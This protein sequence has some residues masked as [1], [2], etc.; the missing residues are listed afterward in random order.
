MA[1]VMEAS[2][3]VRARARAVRLV[4]FDVDG[5]LTD[6]RLWFDD[7]GK[8]MKAFHAQDGLCL[9]LLADHGIA[10]ALITA[11]TSLATLARARDLR[12][13]HVFTAVPDKL[14]CL[15]ALCEKLG[16][17]LD[18]VA[19]MGDDL[20]D[21]PVFPHVALAVGPANSHAW[22]LDRAHWVTPQ[23]GGEGAARAL[24]DLI[25]CERGLR[26]AVLARFGAE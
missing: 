14:V 3:A 23:R 10:V 8:E 15:R 2:E 4:A 5:T 18:E 1:T 19:F 11:R 6:G 24:C 21:L 16:I 17:A 20:S 25:I 22:V 26:D 9:R 7:T 13:D 12:L